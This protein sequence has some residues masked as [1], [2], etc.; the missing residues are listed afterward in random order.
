M[1]MT[2]LVLDVYVVYALCVLGKYHT[3]HTYKGGGNVTG[4]LS[5]PYT[6]LPIWGKVTTLFGKVARFGHFWMRVHA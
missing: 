6:M 3:C 2:Y 4:E 1:C 5:Q